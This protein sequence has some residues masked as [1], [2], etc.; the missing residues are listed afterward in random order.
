MSAPRP[1]AVV[2]A[3]PIS[4]GAN[5]DPGFRKDGAPTAM[6]TAIASVQPGYGNTAPM[7]IELDPTL[8]VDRGGVDTVVSLIRSHF[9]M[10]GTQINMN[11]M[12]ADKVLEANQDPGKYPGPGRCG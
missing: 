8:P 12:D 2:R 4:H 5:P 6:A 10:G 9:D 3:P 7:Q 1:T 11:I